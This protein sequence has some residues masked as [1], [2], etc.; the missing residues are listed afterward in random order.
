MTDV[1]QIVVS[2]L[3][4]V[5]LIANIFFL[6]W[7]NRGKREATLSATLLNLIK[8]AS[9]LTKEAEKARREALEV[10]RQIEKDQAAL[11]RWQE[12]TPF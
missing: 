11:R 12:P 8:S 3:A 1:G 7:N 5:S 9:A 4:A 2:A 6:W 10:K